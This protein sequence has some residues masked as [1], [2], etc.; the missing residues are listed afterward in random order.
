MNQT[1]NSGTP[2]VVLIGAGAMSA[3]LGTVLKGARA[4]AQD[5]DIRDA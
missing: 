2:D 1:Q 3:T 5:H 4:L